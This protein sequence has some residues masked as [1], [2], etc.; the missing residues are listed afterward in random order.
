VAHLIAAGRAATGPL[1]QDPRDDGDRARTGPLAF[2][3]VLYVILGLL[4]FFL[5]AEDASYKHTAVLLG[6]V[7]MV[8]GVVLG[9][10]A[11][12]GIRRLRLFVAQGGIL[13]KLL[14][15]RVLWARMTS[16]AHSMPQPADTQR[17]LQSSLAT[18][19]LGP[20]PSVT[21]STT[22]LLDNDSASSAKSGA[23]GSESE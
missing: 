17:E 15:T 1:K 4:L 5:P 12:V 2:A 21:E 20:I 19:D 7:S 22:T 8:F 9:L 10:G 3:S 23:F 16:T 6:K 14:P 11:A 13:R 18:V